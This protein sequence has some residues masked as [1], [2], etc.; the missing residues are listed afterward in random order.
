MT[1][2]SD[3]GELTISIVPGVMSL[4]AEAGGEDVRLCKGTA[5]RAEFWSDTTACR[6]EKVP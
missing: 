2:Y 3:N 1:A 6:C 4:D 5:V